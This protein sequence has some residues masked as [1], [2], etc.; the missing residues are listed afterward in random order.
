LLGDTV[1]LPLANGRLMRC[2][3]DRM[4]NDDDWRSQSADKNA[5]GHPVTVDPT[6]LACTDGGQGLTLWRLEGDTLSRVTTA[7]VKSRILSR[8]AVLPA[9]GAPG[10]FRVCVA[11]AGRKVTLFQGEMLKKVREWPLSDAIN[12]GPFVRGDSVYVAVGGRRLVCLDPNRPEPRWA[13]TFRADIVGE[14]RFID[15]ALIVADESGQIQALDPT[16]GEPVGLGYTVRAAVAPAASPM[17]YGT[18]QLFVPLTDGTVM[19]L[20]RAWFRPTLFGLQLRR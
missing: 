4:I 7:E 8:P 6:R 19:L 2:R 11:D 1:V 13:H 20:S 18:D 5:V 17:P 14:P 9:A 3:V 12:A 16:T 15:G 10:D